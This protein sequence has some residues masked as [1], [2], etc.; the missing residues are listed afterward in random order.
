VNRP[1]DTAKYADIVKAVL[2]PAPPKPPR[3]RLVSWEIT[4]ATLTYPKRH[5][6]FWFGHPVEPEGTVTVDMAPNGHEATVEFEEYWSLAGAPIY[7]MST[8]QMAPPPYYTITAEYTIR[9]TYEY[10]V[11]HRRT[12]TDKDGKT[13][14][15][16]WTETVRREATTSGTASGKLLVN[17]T[18]VNYL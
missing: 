9:Y 18:G 8:D 13:R 12:Y 15:E 11:T 5:P 14:T 6:D 2:K 1:V 3:G 17:G 7:D 10:E 4:S 16:S